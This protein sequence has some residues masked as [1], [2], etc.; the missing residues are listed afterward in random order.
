MFYHHL[1]EFHED[2]YSYQWEQATFSKLVKMS[3][4][5]RNVDVIDGKLINTDDD[6]MIVD[7]RKQRNVHRFKSLFRTFLGSPSVQEG[8][9]KE[10]VSAGSFPKLCFTKP[11]EREAMKLDTLTK[12]CNYLDVTAQQRKA[13]RFTVC[14]QVCQHRI[15]TETLEEILK[16]LKSEVE[17]LDH[18][19]C[20]RRARISEQIISSC[21]KFLADAAHSFD[22]ESTSWM[23]LAPA[24]KV[25]SSPSRTW[26]EILQMFIDLTK[27]LEK[28]MGSLYH[29]SKVEVMKEGLYQIKD[30][31]V[32]KD[33]GY[34]EARHQESLV[35]KKLS[36]TLGHSSQCLFTLLLY[37]LYGSVR[38]L[39]VE[40]SGGVYKGNGK[41][42]FCLCIGKVLSSDADKAVW[43]GVKQLDRAL[44][45]FK[46]IWESAG[47]KGTL[48]LQGHLWCVGTNYKTLTYRGN[49]FLLHG[50]AL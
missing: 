37:Y 13:V 50:I 16:G 23:R 10:A 1:Q 24:K 26:G 7:V 43:I 8:L 5:L 36:K 41:D 32:D 11:N 22:P 46:F 44:S 47:M 19:S 28:E 15:W 18:G 33:I 2:V 29:L 30:V 3:D 39:E 6:S 27:C 17:L 35:Q 42:T 12:V 40:I 45:L 48:E 38:D 9:K 21:R 49:L 4:T 14:P 20:A 31:L 25:N 34:K